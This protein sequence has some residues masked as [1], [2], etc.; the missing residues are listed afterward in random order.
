MQFLSCYVV[1]HTFDQVV[2]R[3]VLHSQH[4]N[5]TALEPSGGAVDI[6]VCNLDYV[7]ARVIYLRPR[8]TMYSRDKP[9]VHADIGLLDRVAA[10]VVFERD[11]RRLMV[12]VEDQLA[13]MP[14]NK[15]LKRCPAFLSKVQVSRAA[16]LV[17]LSVGLPATSTGFLDRVAAIVVAPSYPRGADILAHG[18]PAV[19]AEISL[20]DR[21]AARVSYLKRYPAIS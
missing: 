15:R 4:C 18:R 11:I 21:V 16:S 13:V 3:V 17:L 14:K 7:A 5:S 6:E 10:D 8:A 9:S 2:E 1:V 20:L 19:H 12:T